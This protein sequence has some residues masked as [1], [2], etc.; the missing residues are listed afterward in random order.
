MDEGAGCDTTCAVCACL[1]R[2][3]FVW[4]CGRTFLSASKCSSSVSCTTRC[5]RTGTCDVC[6][7]CLC[8]VCVVC[9][10]ACV[11]TVSVCVANVYNTYPVQDPVIPR[12]LSAFPCRC[13]KCVHNIHAHVIDPSTACQTICAR[14]L[15]NTRTGL[16]HLRPHG[17]GRA[18]E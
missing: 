17:R 11:L 2:V 13:Q 1:V 10:C 12:A 14:V 8:V 5:S 9:V 7:A 3:S 4:V 18:F 6:V 16:V 15:G